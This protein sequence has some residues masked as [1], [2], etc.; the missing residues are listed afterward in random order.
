VELEELEEEPVELVPD[1]GPL[2]DEELEL[3]ELEE[4]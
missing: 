2:V 4:L 3:D 1:V